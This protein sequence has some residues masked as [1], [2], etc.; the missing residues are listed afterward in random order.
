M[1][2]IRDLVG[3]FSGVAA[4][5]LLCTVGLAGER[6]SAAEKLNLVN[7]SLVM[8]QSLP[9]IAR[10]AGLYRKYGLDLQV[11][12]IASSG[13]VT[14][15]MLGGDAEAALTGGV[16]VVRAFVQG[17]TDF[18]FIGSVKNILTHSVLGKPE[19]TRTEDLKGKK[20]GVT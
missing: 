2:S 17:N 7:S 16:G 4:A 20:I 12:Y 14:A 5:W 11:I 3:T 19:I 15:A 1:S 8:S 9:S 6:A 18:V 13:M 10:D